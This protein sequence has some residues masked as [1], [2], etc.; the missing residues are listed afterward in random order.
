VLDNGFNDVESI[1]G[2]MGDIFD[3]DVDVLLA[4]EVF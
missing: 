1:V 3:D 2:S 4:W